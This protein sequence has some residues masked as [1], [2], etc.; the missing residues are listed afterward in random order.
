MVKNLPAQNPNICYIFSPMKRSLIVAL[1]I[2][3]LLPVQAAAHQLVVLLDSDATAVTGPLLVD[4]TI[5]FA[6]QA[7]FTKAGQKKAFRA[8]LKAE[9]QLAIQ[10]LIVDKK[11]ENALKISMLPSIVVTTPTGKKITI[12][13]N[14]RTKFYEPYGGTNYLYLARFS[15]PAED[16]IY[17]FLITSRAK[18]AITVAVGDREIRGEVRREL[19]TPVG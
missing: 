2:A 12:R 1:A 16:G 6:V 19:P 14:E 13:L 9:D 5:S 4:G 8:G 7:S 11:P 18:S 15:A 17:S 10:Y 3:I